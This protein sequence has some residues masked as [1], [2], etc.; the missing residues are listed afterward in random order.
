[1]ATVPN[2]LGATVATASAAIVAAG[3]TVGTI[4]NV[5]S[6]AIAVG[7]ITFQSII[8][9]ATEAPGTPINLIVSLGPQYPQRIQ[10]I[11]LVLQKSNQICI[12][13]VYSPLG[14]L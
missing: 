3:L 7:I 12:Q 8:G 14:I 10:A 2:V 4:T 13:F 5:Y 9:G 6:A 1:M 11:S